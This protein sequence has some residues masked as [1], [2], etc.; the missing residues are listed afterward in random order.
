MVKERVGSLSWVRKQ[1]EAADKD[2][3]REIVKGMVETLMSREAN[4]LCGAP[5][6]KTSEDR[7]NRRNGYRE[8][9]WDTRVGT[10]DLAIPRLRQGSYFP[11]WLLEPRRRVERVL[12]QVATE[13]YVRGVSTRRVDGLVCTLGLEGMSESQVSQLANELDIVVEGFRTRPLDQGPYT[14][15]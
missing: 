6:R 7:I 5:Y 10:I 12:V 3:L 2:L 8:R 11:D 14:F 9:R 1:V 15:V 13:C 4:S